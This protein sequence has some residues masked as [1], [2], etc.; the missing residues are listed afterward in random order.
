MKRSRPSD[1][2]G[3]ATGAESGG[4]AAGIIDPPKIGVP[5]GGVQYLF[6]AANRGR[7]VDP[8]DRGKFANQP[9][10]R[11]LINLPFAVRLL[12]LPDIA[13]EVAD[14]LGDRRGV[15]GIDLGLVFLSPPA[16]HRPLGLGASLQFR[17]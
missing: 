14:D 8:F 7:L 17:K 1:S 3:G 15:A 5:S 2:V 13:I 4:G 10:E 6:D 11:R 16:P 9:I 12:R